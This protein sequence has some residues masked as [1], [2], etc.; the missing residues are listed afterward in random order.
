MYKTNDMRSLYRASTMPHIFRASVV[1]SVC[2]SV[3]RTAWGNDGNFLLLPRNDPFSCAYRTHKHIY[4][5]HHSSA[6]SASSSGAT[7]HVTCVLLV[8]HVIHAH[9]TCCNAQARWI[10]W[11]FTEKK[12]WNE[13]QTQKGQWTRRRRYRATMERSHTKL[14][15]LWPTPTNS[16]L[17]LKNVGVTRNARRERSPRRWLT[18]FLSSMRLV[19]RVTNRV[20]SPKQCSI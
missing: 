12:K 4:F 6:P 18:P 8:S 3:S 1:S 14:P 17:Q 15:C 9:R 20:H 19:W 16:L 2:A 7:F 5:F 10:A 13:E 11:T